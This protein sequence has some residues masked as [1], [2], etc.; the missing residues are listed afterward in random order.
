[1]P[2]EGVIFT[3]PVAPVLQTGFVPTIVVATAEGAVKVVV[4]VTVHPPTPVTV[5][6]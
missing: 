2:P 6:V 1:V 3:E 4:A 5:T